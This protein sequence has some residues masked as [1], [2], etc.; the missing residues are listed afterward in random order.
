MA[1]TYKMVMD[2]RKKYPVGLAF[3]LRQHCAIIDK[4]LKITSLTF[5]IYY[6]L[7]FLKNQ[8]LSSRLAIKRF[9]PSI[10]NNHYQRR[11]N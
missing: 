3:R 10:K 2:F 9:T 7:F 6:I 1:K 11:K 5:Y 8:K 4:H